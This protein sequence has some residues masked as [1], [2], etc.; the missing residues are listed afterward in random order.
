MPAPSHVQSTRLGYMTRTS[1][2]TRLADFARDAR[3]ASRGLARD[4]TFTATALLTLVVCLSANA[5]IF[6]I[7]R[8]VVLKPLPFDAPDQLVILSNIYPKAG[9]S[10]TGPAVVG[11]GAPDYFD[12]LRETTVFTEQAMY[13]RRNPTLG[14]ENGV[15]RVAAIAATPSFFRLLGA[16]A[17]RGRLF[18]EDDAEP[19]QTAK[20]VL[21]HGFWQRQYG[22]DPSIVGRDIRVNGRPYTVVG[23][24]QPDFRYL[25]NEVDLWLPLAF[26]PAERGDDR[27]HS[28]NWT[29]LARLGPNVTLAA[30][31]RQIDDLNARNN[32][33][34]PQFAPLLRDAGF[35]TVVSRLQDDLIRDIRPT[36][37]LLW[38]GVLLVLLVG[39][40][41][42]A[43]L[44]LVRAAGRAR[45]LATRHA[46]GAELPRLARQLITET[47]LL[48]VVGAALGTIA[49][50]WI[51]RSASALHLELLPRGEEITLD[52]QTA[53]LMVALAITVGLLAGLMPVTQLPRA[54]LGELLREGGRGG[55]SGSASGRLRR[56][57]A[58]T[59]VALAFV[60]LVGAGLLLASFRAVLRIDA[61]FQPAGVTTASITLPSARYADADALVGVTSRLLASLRAIPGVSA[62]GATTSIPLGGDY[63]SSVIL[64]EGY[65]MKPGESLVSPNSVTVTDGYFEAMSIKLARGRFFDARDTPT[66][67]PVIIIDETLAAHFWP[68]QDPIGR[69]MYAPTNPNDIGA[70][71]PATRFLTVVGVTKNI[72]LT[73]LTPR[74]VPVGAYFFPYSQSTS[75]GLVLAVRA[76][77]SADVLTADVRSAIASVDRELPVFNIQSMENRLDQA[78][79]PRRVPML[80]GIVFGLIALFLAAVGI[81][82]VLA[83]QVSQRQREIGIRLAL[84]STAREIVSLVLRDGIRITGIGLIAG[85]VGMLALTRVIRGLLYGVEP[86]NVGVIAVVLVVLATVAL[87]ATLLPARRAARVSPMA[88]LTD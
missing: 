11:A 80:I 5:A 82:G 41:N 29:M 58:V 33:R 9:F 37:Y 38:G 73:G 2:G 44:T 79:V 77:R 40:V 18:A 57:L 64:A 67:P 14:I 59:Q 34:F 7:L 52:W 72:R 19:G 27:R 49:G 88:A 56:A 30:A 16:R 50:W 8:S 78:L 48:T 76:E 53:A 4:R 10:N 60:L 51:L 32:E 45:E 66:S 25:W 70:I 81:Y 6:G 55:T 22:S 68:N 15:Q 23:V 84:G 69:R 39:G 74:D 13:A 61:G 26:S 3:F 24:M 75:T 1:F 36:L 31:Q 47:T 54:N 12:R 43:N 20:A 71:T 85:F 63:N 62:A 46:L 65:Q 17:N 21:A 83:Y 87:V 28:N 35:R 86:L 42:L